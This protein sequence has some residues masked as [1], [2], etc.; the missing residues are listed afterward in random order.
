MFSVGKD[1]N[2]PNVPLDTWYYPRVPW[3]ASQPPGWPPVIP[4]PGVHSLGE[5]SPKLTYGWP[6]S[7]IKY[8][9]SDSV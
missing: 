8:G 6:V 5:Y 4:S 1:R 2:D 9:R 3:Y 7:P